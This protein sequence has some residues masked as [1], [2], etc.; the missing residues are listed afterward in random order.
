MI[1]IKLWY[2]WIIF[3]N[4]IQRKRSYRRHLGFPYNLIRFYFKCFGWF[5]HIFLFYG[6]FIFLVK[7]P[8][9]KWIVFWYDVMRRWLRSYWIE[10]YSI[11]TGDVAHEYFLIHGLSQIQILHFW[12]F[13][14]AWKY[15][16]VE[17]VLMVWESFFLFWTKIRFIITPLCFHWGLDLFQLFIL[18][19]VHFLPQRFHTFNTTPWSLQPQVVLWI[20]H[21]TTICSI[22]CL[23]ESQKSSVLNNFIVAIIYF[24]LLLLDFNLRLLILSVYAIFLNKTS[25]MIPMQLTF[26]L[27]VLL[28]FYN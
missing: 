24:I 22:R 12:F 26:T 15:D 18:Y 14:S 17:I 27:L 4:H 3:G 25:L 28:H 23:S 5:L 16:P 2:F 8:R 11:T 21:I 9:R 13:F 19:F 20:I 1:H 6:R 10:I 7:V